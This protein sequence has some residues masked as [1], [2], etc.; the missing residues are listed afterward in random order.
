[1]KFKYPI[2][3][4]DIANSY[5][6]TIIGNDKLMATGLN[7]IHKVED[8]DITFVDNEKYYSKSLN[9]DATIIIIDKEVQ[10]PQGKAL[11]L[12]ENPF[13]IFN[14]LA[15]NIALL[16]DMMAILDLTTLVTAR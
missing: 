15:K 5:N 7:E 8:G 6:L 11:L 3:I 10:C 1:M 4:Q 13:E 2:S 14:D 16:R 12:H 9:S